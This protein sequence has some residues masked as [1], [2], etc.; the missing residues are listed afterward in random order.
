MAPNF[1]QRA[2]TLALSTQEY[3][4]PRWTVMIEITNLLTG[5]VDAGAAV[6]LCWVS[7]T[8]FQS[9]DRPN[10]KSFLSVVLALTAWALF[11]F[12]GGVSQGLSAGLLAGAS[13][14]GRFL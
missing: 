14:L 6:L 3:K 12:T 9:R 5:L 11:T 4:P 8:V 2:P 13:D 10:F 1:A 7:W